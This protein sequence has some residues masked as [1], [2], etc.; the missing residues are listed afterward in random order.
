MEGGFPYY[1]FADI[2]GGTEKEG[3]REGDFTRVI[4]IA[5]SQDALAEDI[6]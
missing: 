3:C 6:E 2:G 4:D 1:Y 5:I